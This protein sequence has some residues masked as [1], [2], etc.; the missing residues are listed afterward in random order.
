MDSHFLVATCIPVLGVAGIIMNITAA[1]ILKVYVCMCVQAMCVGPDV[2]YCHA[3][4]ITDTEGEVT[5]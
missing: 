2:R 1:V 3:R 5:I 4:V